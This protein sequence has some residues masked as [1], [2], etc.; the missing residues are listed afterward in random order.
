ME[1]KKERREVIFN[2]LRCKFLNT[3]ILK[4]YYQERLNRSD[5][6]ELTKSEQFSNRESGVDEVE[7]FENSQSIQNTK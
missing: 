3:R 5:L 4:E 6:H 2:L 1:P 7:V